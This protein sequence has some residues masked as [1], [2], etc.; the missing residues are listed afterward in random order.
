[1][2][3]EQIRETDTLNQGRIKINNIL[4]AANA[5]SEKVDSY[6]TQLNT[7]IDEAKK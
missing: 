1:M 2:A 7:G 4:E 5:S 6:Q 3:V